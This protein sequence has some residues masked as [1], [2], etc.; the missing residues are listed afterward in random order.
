MLIQLLLKSNRHFMA[1]GLLISKRKRHTAEQI[2]KKLRDANAMLAAGKT[3]GEVLQTLAVNEATLSRWRSKYGGMKSDS[4]TSTRRSHPRPRPRPKATF[5]K[6]CR[7]FNCLQN[8]A[9]ECGRP[10]CSNAKTGNSSGT[11]ASQLCSPTK[12]RYCDSSLPF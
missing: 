6:V 1:E 9:R 4:P 3:V 7:S 2:V 5:Q 10:T 8:T 11:H 12:R